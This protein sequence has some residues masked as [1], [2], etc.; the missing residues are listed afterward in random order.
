MASAPP[1]VRRAAKGVL[2][3]LKP[4]VFVRLGCALL[5]LAITASCAYYNTFYLAR[6]YY[7][8]ATDGQPYEVDRDGTTQRANYSKSGEYC[9]KVLGVYPRSKWVDDAYLMWARTF[10]GIDDPLK[11]VAM[12]EEFQERY[13]KSEL[14][15][16]AEFFLGLAY[17]AARK[18]AEALAAFDEFLAQAP[19]HQL[20]PYAWYER[21]KA[22]MSL[23]RYR[24]AA[25]SA[26][27]VLDNFKGSTLIDR[28]LRQRAEAL[29][30]QG[31]YPAA[32]ADFHTMG[33]RALTDDERLRFLLREVDCLESARDYTQARE[34]LRDARSHTPPPPPLPVVP[35]AG[36]PGA[37]TGDQL[38]SNPLQQ[39]AFQR[40]PEQER[41]GKITIRMG[42]VELLDGKVDKA[43]E[44]YRSVLAD[45]PRSQLAA[46]A[47]YR[48]GFAYETGADDFSR[49][50]SEYA[51]VKEQVG[52]SQFAQQADQRL[53]N[54]DRIERYR[55]AGG[56][57]SL[58]R[59]AEARFLTAEHYLFNLQRPERA[60][61]EYRSIV[62]SVKVPGVQARALNA[63]AWV[64]S[65]KLEKKAEADSLFW[66]VVREYPETEGQLA[67]R[68]YLEAEG[69]TVPSHLI[70]PPKIATPPVLDTA[71]DDELTAPPS[72]TPGLGAKREPSIAEPGAVRFGPGVN[73][74]TQPTLTPSSLRNRMLP[75]SLRRLMATRDSLVRLARSDTT[76]AGR[77]RVDSL[78][79]AFARPD[80]LGRG[81]L[82]AEIQQQVG[83]A[84]GVVLAPDSVP[85]PDFAHVDS[86]PGSVLAGAAAGAA[87]S[88]LTK[89]AK[90]PAAPR[91]APLARKTS[92][93]DSLRARVVA[94]SLRSREVSDSLR[95]ATAADSMRMVFEAQRRRVV[96][97]SLEQVAVMRR[98]QAAAD[99]SRRA[100]GVADS[101]AHAKK[102][103]VKIKPP[104]DPNLGFSSV[105]TKDE[106]DSVKQAKKL[107][108]QLAK[109]QEQQRKDEAA[110]TKKLKQD[111]AKQPK[112]TKDK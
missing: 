67:A 46:E 78:R 50:R 75:D 83:K 27:K 71:D 108:K 93:A 105:W 107:A 9:K 45:Y 111:T 96:A 2:G 34:L 36:T 85:P 68:D 38:A 29:F 1:V 84:N 30:Q 4:R 26:S 42:G 55:T 6:K 37:P 24:D 57:D 92:R 91:V 28:A 77:A 102:K 33:N 76:T 48:V 60:L 35:R 32:Q 86:L 66:K 104:V 54:L 10:L 8:K 80:T 73:A 17:R 81:A 18:H 21:S 106:P 74:P 15:P 5:L 69:I 23:Q 70:V 31:D 11:A 72:S 95:I 7:L 41:Y 63:Q 59:K 39:Q 89:T 88:T 44:F 16:D 101:L 87:A 13:P 65:R 14:R 52:T 98:I 22:L 64:L 12:L 20:A 56:A 40:T 19:K 109:Q 25:E 99:S 61:E 49:A 103:P 47:Q 100:N 110:A 90:L 82:M 53:E 58:A 79:H 94:D 112:P 62:D 97:D 3:L 43:V 51:K